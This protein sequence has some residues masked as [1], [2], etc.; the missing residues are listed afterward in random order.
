MADI[1]VQKSA[2]KE[3][4]GRPRFVLVIVGVVVL[5]VLA[6]FGWRWWEGRHYESTDDAHVA[7]D[8]VPVLAKVGGYVTSVTVED[9]QRVKQGQPLVT[10]DPSE[11]QQRLQQAQAQLRAAQQA[12]GTRASVGQTE[13]QAQAAQA[14]ASAA[15]A[16]IAQAEANAKKAA[17][18]V[19]R[20][21]P[22]AEQGI[23][24][25]QQY[26]AAVA[27][28]DAA[29]AQLTAARQNAQAARS[30][31]QAAQATVGGAQDQV[32][33]AK[34]AVEQ[35]QL[36]LSYT[37]IVAPTSGVVAKKN[38]QVGQLVNPG[39]ALMTVVPLDS[40][41]VE[42]NMK[43]TQLQYLN[44][45]DSVEIH[46]DAYP[47]ETFHGVVESVSPATGSTFALIPP[48]N[49][50]GNYTKVVQRVPV[51]IQVAGSND[52]KHPLRPGMNA[53]VK[54]KVK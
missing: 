51:R 15:Q 11:L 19:S 18:D 9:N 10:I 7:G 13:A 28:S 20:L 4:G 31:V 41:W 23:V 47:D 33:S 22:L 25:K 5:A 2:A 40:V 54:V 1:S 38:V 21:R 37:H 32:T 24:S 35:A 30:Q 43:E 44:A 12:A 8:V 53:V 27:A 34:V 36:Q 50:T 17:S 14:Q 16:A 29:Q 48:D 49:A 6:Y 39:Q 52:R 26:D 3:G 45:G 46:V 42:A